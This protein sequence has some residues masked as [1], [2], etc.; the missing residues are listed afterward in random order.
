MLQKLI[1]SHRHQLLSYS[2]GKEDVRGLLIKN[3]SILHPCTD[4][5]TQMNEYNAWLHTYIETTNH[6]IS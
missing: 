4:C 1:A 2:R 5:S 3:V 6:G